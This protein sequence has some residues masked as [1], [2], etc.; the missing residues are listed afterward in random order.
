MYGFSGHASPIVASFTLV[1]AK[2]NGTGAQQVAAGE[3]LFNLYNYD[4]SVWQVYGGGY[5]KIVDALSAPGANP[6]GGGYL[7]S[8]SGA[9]VW[10]GSSGTITTIA[11]ADP[12]C[13]KCGKDFM[14]EWENE[15]YGYLAV[16]MNCLADEVGERPWILR[17]KRKVG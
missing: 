16:C 10:R 12:H 3:M 17:N 4:T 14:H 13:P 15:K 11:P 9:L 5:H 1:G 7:Y 2:K 8:S 6:T